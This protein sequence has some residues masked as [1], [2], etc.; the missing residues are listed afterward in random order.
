MSEVTIIPSPEFVR[1]AKRFAKK[2]KSFDD[3]LVDLQDE[4]MKNPFIGTDLGGGKR[5]IRMSVESKGKGKRGGMRVITF[6]IVRTEE[7][8]TVYLVT[9][10]DKSEYTSVSDHYVNQ[11]I[12]NLK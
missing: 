11:I 3:D 7:T 10:Y 8:I 12:K 1:Q 4:L 2:Y 6:S 5:K 9:I